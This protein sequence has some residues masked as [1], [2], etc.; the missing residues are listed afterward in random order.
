MTNTTNTNSRMLAKLIELSGDKFF[1]CT[2]VKKNGETRTINA[3]FKSSGTGRKPNVN[4][5]QYLTVYEPNRGY[6]SINKD[7]IL[8]VSVK[9]IQAVTTK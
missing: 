3:R 2:F 9:G 6:R 7:T 1:S 8:A 4:P 5:E